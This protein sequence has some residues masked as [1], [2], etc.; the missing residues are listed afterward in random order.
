MPPT[1]P[2][3]SGGWDYHLPHDA[4]TSSPEQADWRWCNKCQGL[5]YR[6]GVADSHCPAGGRHAPVA[7]SGSW[8]YQ[9]PYFL[10]PF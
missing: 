9:L 2:A 4:S 5:F 1:P 6:G 7:E 3:Q 8:D 10:G